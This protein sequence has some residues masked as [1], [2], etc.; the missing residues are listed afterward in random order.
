MKHYVISTINDTLS[1]VAMK[2][3]NAI[4]ELWDKILYL[5]EQKLEAIYVPLKKRQLEILLDWSKV[6][7]NG[8]TIWKIPW[9]WSWSI[10]I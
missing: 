3:T 2:I 4:I 9:D 8:Q 6:K 10:M 7:V 5:S 1:E